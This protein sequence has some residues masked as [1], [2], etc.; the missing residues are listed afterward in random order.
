MLI[1]YDDELLAAVHLAVRRVEADQKTIDTK[2]FAE[3]YR[4]FRLARPWFH[5]I[6]YDAYDDPDLDRLYVQG[7]REHAK[8]STVL[9]YVLRRIC[10]NHRLRV[11]IVS[12]SDPLAMKFLGEIKHELTSNVALQRRYNGGKSFVGPKWTE[13]ELVLADARERGP[14]GEPGL[15][16]KDVTLFAVGRG[17]QISSRHC[18][19]LIVDDVESADSVRSD[20]VRQGTREWW[21]R[22]VVPV[23]SPG[24][25]LIVVGTRKHYD[26]LYSYLIKDDRWTV[27]DQARSVF[28]EDG[29]PIWPE[30]WS[31]EALLARK[32]E[33]DAQDILAWPQEY[34]NTPLPAETQMFYP[35][36]W[37]VYTRA[38]KDMEIFQYWD[39]AISERTAADYTVGWTIGVTENNDVY[40][41]ERVRGHFN[42]NRTLAEIEA[43]GQRWPTVQLI[44]I[45][46]VAYQAAAVQEALRRTM[47]PIVPDPHN[48]VPGAKK[49]GPNDKVTRARLL[50]ARANAGK[51]Y[52]PAESKWW[53]DFATEAAF[54]PAGAHDDQIDS[55][56]GAIKIAGGGSSSVSW[57]YGVWTCT[58]CKHM[59]TWAA[60]RPCPKCG[61][62]AP[63]EFENP[64]LATQGAMG[65]RREISPEQERIIA[66]IKGGEQI[67]WI[68]D[69]SEWVYW[70]ADTQAVM[71]YFRD[72]KD[73]RS[74]QAALDEVR[75]L[76]RI[77]GNGVHA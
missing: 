50:E 70:R 35:E 66:T 42:F 3:T 40:M 60:K 77:F 30:M 58:Q 73:D 1:P 48:K 14:N 53:T 19:L 64:E 38:P 39:L 20:L 49:E 15:P 7:P 36:E 62:P 24:G 11:G 65:S 75:R 22:E 23:L 74:A 12:G 61:K 34:L 10:E 46:Q 5:D 71:G 13:H 76:D 4:G 43:M 29:S 25:K 55:L 69:S 72:L 47:L 21:S 6:W 37:P 56:T 33:L 31:E 59:F 17:G 67:S 68:R 26:D 54:F 16:G 57:Q 2:Q 52:R 41:L 9:T 18:D 8:T 63:E 28:R 27:L 51:V 32:A 44:G 45:E